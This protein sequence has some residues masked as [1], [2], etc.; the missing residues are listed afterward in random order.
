MF[1]TLLAV[2]P[3]HTK[4]S[5][6][7]ALSRP[8]KINNPFLFYASLPFP[9]CLRPCR[10]SLPG[11]LL[12]FSRCAGLVSLAGALCARRAG[13]SLRSLP[14]AGTRCPHGKGS[15]CVPAGGSDVLRAKRRSAE[16]PARRAQRA[17]RRAQRGSEA[18]PAKREKKKE[19]PAGATCQGQPARGNLPGAT[20]QG[21]TWITKEWFF[22]V[23]VSVCLSG[24]RR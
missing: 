22:L 14:P 16:E 6:Q 2:H 21:A 10:P 4:V 7:T 20:C 3:R 23:V 18:I 5:I 24:A 17:E 12:F 13:S 15:R 1:S 9:F 11:A 8:P 19:P